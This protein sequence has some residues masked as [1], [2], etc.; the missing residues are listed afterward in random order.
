MISWNKITPTSAIFEW[1]YPLAYNQIF[2]IFLQPINNSKEQGWGIAPLEYST[3]KI[4]AT[5]FF[6][7]SRT[8][9]NANSAAKRPVYVIFI[10]N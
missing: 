8:F 3:Y 9:N 2:S 4:T 6:T 10:G 5:K 7:Y 1:Q